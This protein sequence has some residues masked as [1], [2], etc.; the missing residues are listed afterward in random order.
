VA[1]DPGGHVVRFRNRTVFITGASSGI[2]AALARQFASEGAD[3][4]LAAR[5]E[6]KLREVEASLPQPHGTVRRVRCDV[7]QDGD[8]EAAVAQVGKLDIVIANAGFGVAGNVEAI[9]LEDYRRQF[10]TNVFGVL[11]T[12][13]ATLAELKR[14]RGQLVIIGSVAGYVP[15]PGT[16]AYGMSKFAVLALAE[17]LRM[18]LAPQGIAVTLI[19]PGFVASDIRRTDNRGIVHPNARDRIPA[20]LVVFADRAA[21]EIA[22]AV[23][24]RKRERIVT[25]HGKAVVFVYRHAPWLV[26]WFQRR[27]IKGRPEPS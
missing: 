22:N 8:L 6:D 26:R 1:G 5:R 19:S 4:V 11:R 16:S 25:G 13:Y 20:W 14:T 23:Y 3:L 24:R 9:T 27:G 7:T 12:F 2:G 17:S 10:E 21:R 15:Q 18:E